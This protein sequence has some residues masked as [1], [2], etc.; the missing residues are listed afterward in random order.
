MAVTTRSCRRLA[1][2]LLAI[3]ACSSVSDSPQLPSGRIPLTQLGAETYKG[4]A[5][6]LHPDGQNAEPATHAAAGLTR[7]QGLAPLDIDGMPSPSGTIVLVSVGMSNT[8]QEFCSGGSTATNCSSWSFMGQAAADANVNHTTLT[9]VNGARGGQDA[10]TW[11]SSIDV[12]YDSVRLNR[13]E[14][15]GLSENQVQVVWIKEANAGPRDSLPSAQADAYRLET[16]LG[17]IVRALKTRYANLKLVFLSS[18][19][20]AGYATTTLNPEPYAYE[21]GFAVKWLIE[22]Q[23]DQMEAGGGLVDARA[24][25]LNYESGV[26]PWLGWGP[27]LWADGMTA[28]AGDG[29]TWARTDLAADGTHPSQ[30]GQQKVGAL[31]LA[32]FKGSRFTKCWFVSG[33]TCP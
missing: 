16:T 29:L 24:G 18:R 21:S 12:N 4:F 5:G 6:G 19:I 32:F 20:Y 17:N 8:T 23:I 27:Y 3:A 26:A 30:S 25:D 33:G 1:R 22:A 14:P 7:A 11:D 2:L 10:G 9:I 28:R 15:L 13:L 31:L